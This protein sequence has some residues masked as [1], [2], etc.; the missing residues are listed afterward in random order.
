MKESPVKKLEDK[1]DGLD[2]K[3]IKEEVQ[4]AKSLIQTFLQTVKIS[5]LYE[6]NHPMISRFLDNLKLEFDR[7]FE[8]LDSFS[9]KVGQYQLLYRERWL[10]KARI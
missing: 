10:M 5:Q 2:E 7:Y 9:L 6:P 8:D 1:T 4:S 3:N